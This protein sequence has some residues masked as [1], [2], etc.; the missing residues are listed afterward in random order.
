[1]CWLQLLFLCLMVLPPLLFEVV[2]FVAVAPTM[3]G[4]AG[5]MVVLLLLLTLVLLL[6]RPYMVRH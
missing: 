2:V 6:L 1:M 3:H 4:Q 5:D